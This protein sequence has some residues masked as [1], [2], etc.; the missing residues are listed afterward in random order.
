M[1]KLTQSLVIILG[2]LQHLLHC[3]LHRQNDGRIGFSASLCVHSEG[4][5]K[6]CKSCLTGPRQGQAD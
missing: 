5:K 2:Q 6:V 3:F 1:S 4:N